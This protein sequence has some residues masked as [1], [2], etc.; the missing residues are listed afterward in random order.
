[1]IL[2]TRPNVI[3]VIPSRSSEVEFNDVTSHVV[4]DNSSPFATI[5]IGM[6]RGQSFGAIHD[7]LL[8]LQKGFFL[9]LNADRMNGVAIANT[10]NTNTSDHNEKGKVKKDKPS[11]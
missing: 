3:V 8:E 7:T 5:S 2:I 11:H 1:M 4:A 9:A 10:N 6:P